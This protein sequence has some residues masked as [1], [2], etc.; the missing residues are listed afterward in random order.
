M[1]LRVTALAAAATA[2]APPS[3]ALRVTALAAVATATAPPFLTS[4]ELRPAAR[5][6]QEECPVLTKI[7]KDD[8]T[9]V[10]DFDALPVCS[11]ACLCKAVWK[12]HLRRVRPESPRRS[13]RHRLDACSMA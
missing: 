10:K 12:S 13:P 7:K 5:R 3:P 9:D 4:K 8:C 6:T 11:D 2:L 1:L